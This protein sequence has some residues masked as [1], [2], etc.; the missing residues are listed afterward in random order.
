MVR[1][2]SSRD[3]LSGGDE[4]RVAASFGARVG[5]ARTG[6]RQTG[7]RPSAPLQLFRA[8]ENYAGLTSKDRGAYE[9]LKHIPLGGDSWLSLGGE[10]R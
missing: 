4:L 9:Q 5:R 10:L 7:A 6:W 8:D 3:R 1:R 2:G